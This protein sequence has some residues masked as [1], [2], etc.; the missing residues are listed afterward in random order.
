MSRLRKARYFD[1]RVMALA[2]AEL[3]QAHPIANHP[4]FMSLGLTILKIRSIYK[5]TKTIG[6]SITSTPVSQCPPPRIA[7]ATNLAGSNDGQRNR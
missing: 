4:I 1:I 5:N 6:V 2:K 3:N 7:R